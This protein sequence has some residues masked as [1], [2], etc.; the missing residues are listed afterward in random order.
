MDEG[1]CSLRRCFVL[2]VC[3]TGSGALA[4][5]TASPCSSNAERNAPV[6]PQEL[7]AL[8]DQR[9]QEELNRIKNHEPTST[10][11]INSKRFI[12]REPC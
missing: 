7:K 3:R 6:S 1:R 12:A 10:V 5:S 11:S 9:V 8:V 4:R 2:R